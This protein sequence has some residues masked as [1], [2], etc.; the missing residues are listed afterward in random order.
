MS[1]G[2]STL[3]LSTWAAAS[4]SWPYSAIAGATLVVGVVMILNPGGLGVKYVEWYRRRWARTRGVAALH[5]PRGTRL[6][7]AMYGTVMVVGSVVL[8]ILGWG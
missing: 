7:S 1:V 5:T 3:A 2:G 4:D 6:A 8:L